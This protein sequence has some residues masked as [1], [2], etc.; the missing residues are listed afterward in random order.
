M[1]NTIYATLTRQSGL[2]RE[3]QSIAHNIANAS[4]GGYRREGVLF[5]EYVTA[6]EGPG[7]A[8]AMARA[9]VRHIDLGQAPLTQ[10]NA[11]LDFAIEGEG[12][13]MVETPQGQRLTRAGSFTPNEMGELVTPDGH[14]LL[15]AG[16]AP[17]FMPPDTADVALSADG[18]LS[19]G[20]RPVAD[21][22]LVLPED[23]TRM[24]RQSGT[25]FDPDGPTLPADTARL[26]Q[27]YL[28]Q[29]NVDPIGETARMIE[30]QRAYE[31]GQNFLSREDD[32]IRNVI[33][34]LGQ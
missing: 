12:F 6:L 16:G 2:M 13:F 31:L 22:G 15:D 23:P 33:R 26:L 3:M 14:R 11:P 30:V 17:V 25:L 21:I 24:Q 34:T 20:G 9:N 29:S 27:G 10:T 1:D 19:A 18:A 4:T 28:E 5:S 7:G 32:R 8:L